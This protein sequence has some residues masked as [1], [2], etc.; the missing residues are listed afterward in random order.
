MH[1]TIFD[2]PIINTLMHWLSRLVLRLLGWRVEGRAPDAAKY[3]LIA[4]PQ[5]FSNPGMSLKAE[6]ISSFET[7]VDG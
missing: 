5:V 3:V 2:T 1:F 4:A 6:G 7:R